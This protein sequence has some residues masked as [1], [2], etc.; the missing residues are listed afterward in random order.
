MSD[1][2][3]NLS[4]LPLLTDDQIEDMTENYRGRLGAV[5]A[6]D[7]QI[8]KIVREVRRAGEMNNTYFIFNSD[9]GYLQGEHRLRGSKF[10][11]YEN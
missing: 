1:K 3:I 5:R 11:P 9:N 7:Y 10:L 4:G 8:G 6:V 2:E